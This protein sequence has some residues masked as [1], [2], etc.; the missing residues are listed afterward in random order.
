[1]NNEI[2]LSVVIP[3]YNEEETI[4]ELL[5]ALH[6]QDFPHQALEVVIADGMS[7]DR[8]RQKIKT[9]QAEHPDFQ[10]VLIDNPDRTIPAALNR[11]IAAA[12]GKYLL[13][14]DAHVSPH[15]GYLRK[16]LQ[17]LE[18]GR[19]DNVGG[20]VE[21]RPGADTW[22]GR[23]IAVAVAHPLGVGDARYRIGSQA[24][25]V[26]TVPFGAYHRS[27][28]DEIGPY[29]ETLLSNED[30]EFNVRVRKAGGVVWL[31]P[32]IRSTYV[33]RA[34]FRRLAKQ[35]WR[36]GYWKLRMLLKHPD[37]FRWRQLSGGFVLSWLLLGT[38]SLWY[39][40]ARI[41][42]AAEALIY[43]GALAAVGISSAVKYR[44][45]KLGIGVPLAV[46]LM[47]FS[48]GSGFLWSAL[49]AGTAAV[50]SLFTPDGDSQQ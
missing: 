15:E 36:Y 31:D 50:V 29:D 14:L 26:D 18:A 48:W 37:T 3:C 34:N 30:Y 38:L 2:L 16:S 49:K 9:F 13:R 6:A 42:L 43:G 4:R 1:M 39:P 5:E 24:R 35:Y 44:E 45:G 32:A 19:G 23:S 17:A 41:L 25:A 7:T 8:T 22:V 10:I 27:L 28:I 20:V 21:M 12:E 33:S 40:L 47:H 46:G 11:A